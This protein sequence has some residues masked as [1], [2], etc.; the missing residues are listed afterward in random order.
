M[1]L[2][3]SS[4]Q[5][6]RKSERLSS[7][8][9]IEELVLRGKN[10]SVPPLRMQW[11]SSVMNEKVPVQAAFSV[12]KKNFK[13]AVERN[14]IK[15]RLK[16]AYRKNKSNLYSLISGNKNQYALLF[17]YMGKQIIT[18]K[19]TEEKTITILDRFVEDLKKNSG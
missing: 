19:E 16:E 17:V 6:F 15:R 4:R 9:T 3:V 12:P 11:I 13:K 7:R 18:Y 10:I 1:L 5:T 14:G 2:P 8:K